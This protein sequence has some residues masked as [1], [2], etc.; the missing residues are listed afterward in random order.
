[1]TEIPYF[2]NL[3]DT[4]RLSLD[5][6]CMLGILSALPLLVHEILIVSE[7][8]IKGDGLGE[9]LK[10]ENAFS[11]GGQKAGDAEAS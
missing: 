3:F 2:V 7:G 10:E 11:Q 8:F 5:E 6:W 4:T 1:M 9:E